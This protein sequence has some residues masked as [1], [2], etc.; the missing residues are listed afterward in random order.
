MLKIYQNECLVGELPPTR[1]YEIIEHTRSRLAPGTVGVQGWIS[2]SLGLVDTITLHVFHRGGTSS[3]PAPRQRQSLYGL[4]LTRSTKVLRC[5]CGSDKR[6]RKFLT[7]CS[8]HTPLQADKGV[9]VSESI[10]LTGG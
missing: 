7:D 2:I 3:R 6:Q 5:E 4:G 8:W 1:G 9:E 10:G